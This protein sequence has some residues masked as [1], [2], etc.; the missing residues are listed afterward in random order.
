MKP[1]QGP[2]PVV[3]KVGGSLFDLPDL[4]ARLRGF[5]REL[6]APNVILVPGGGPTADVVRRLDVC[7]RLGE[8][9]AHLLALR[10][11]TVNAHFLTAVL[12]PPR[13]VMVSGWEGAGDTWKASGTTVL[14]AYRFMEADEGRPGALPP[15]WEVT[16]DSVAARLAVIAGARHLFLLKS[17]TLPPGLDWLEAGRRGLVDGFFAHVLA[18]ASDLVIRCVNLRAGRSADDP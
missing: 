12:S 5:L 18:A 13:P 16:S 17:V 15:T 7:H 1:D 11:L 4:G 6:A 10:A 8:E 14:D 3:V 2:F 9:S